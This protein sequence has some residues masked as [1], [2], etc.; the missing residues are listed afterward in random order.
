VLRNELW[1]LMTMP[2]SR[3]VGELGVEVA[4]PPLELVDR[5]PRSHLVRIVEHGA[6]LGPRD[7]RAVVGVG[8]VGHAD[9]RD[10]EAVLAGHLGHRALLHQDD[11]ARV[12]CLDGVG[13]RRGVV[14]PGHDDVAEPAMGREVGDGAAVG[15]GERRDVR[16]RQQ[17]QQFGVVPHRPGTE[18][19][20]E[21]GDEIHDRHSIT[22][23]DES[24][25]RPPIRPHSAE[26]RSGCSPV[27][28]HCFRTP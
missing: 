17:I 26:G 27:R 25:T 21:I 3:G 8:A 7:Q 12:E 24:A 16:R 15:A 6:R 20:A 13:D 23:F 28:P 4:R 9:H 19:L 1:A 5:R 22:T 2:R 14:A 18:A 10:P 11:E